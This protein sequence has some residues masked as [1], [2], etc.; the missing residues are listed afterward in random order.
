MKSQSNQNIKTIE[1]RGHSACEWT[2]MWSVWNLSWGLAKKVL[3]HLCGTFVVFWT[4]Q[5]ELHLHTVLLIQHCFYHNAFS[6]HYHWRHLTT[7]LS[8]R[9]TVSMSLTLTMFHW[10]TYLQLQPAELSCGS[11]LCHEATPRVHQRD[12]SHL[13][14]LWLSLTFSVK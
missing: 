6:I 7:G 8:T 5:R 4:S 9:T 2:V 13:C 3:W 10:R 11:S 12:S 14:K 1:N